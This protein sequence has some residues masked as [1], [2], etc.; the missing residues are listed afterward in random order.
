[1]I[2]AGP[3]SVEEIY[4]LI[5]ISEED[6]WTKLD[7]IRRIGFEFGGKRQSSSGKRFFRIVCSSDAR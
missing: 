7:F 3:I 5:S 4:Y 6:K 1:M 2:A